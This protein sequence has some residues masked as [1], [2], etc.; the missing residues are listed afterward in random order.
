VSGLIFGHFHR[1]YQLCSCQEDIEHE[2]KLFFTRLLDRGYSLTSLIPL[3]LN[4]EEKTKQ[5]LVRIQEQQQQQPSQQ[6]DLH[7][8]HHRA[9]QQTHINRDVFFHL[10]YHPANPPSREIQQLWR[11]SVM[12]P[13][14]KMPLTQ[15]A[16]RDGHRISIRKLTVAYSRAPNLGNILSCRKLRAKIREYTDRLP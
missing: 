11:T 5:H 3:F 1:V 12:T 6:S 13:P 2:I 15:L 16:N 8:H 14:N 9:Q 7:N 4:A 10:A